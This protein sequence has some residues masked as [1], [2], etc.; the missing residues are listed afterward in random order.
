VKGVA[1]SPAMRDNAAAQSAKRRTSMGGAIGPPAL[2]VYQLGQV[3]K[4][5]AVVN[6]TGAEMWRV[7]L[8]ALQ[9]TNA[10]SA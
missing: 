3:R 7:A 9:A 2:L 4:E 1:Q 5:A 8:P 6:G 10:A